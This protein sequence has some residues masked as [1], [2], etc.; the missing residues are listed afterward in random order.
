MTRT[1]S[2][3]AT[4]DLRRA[5]DQLDFEMVDV[6]DNLSMP[7]STPAFFEFGESPCLTDADEIEE[8]FNASEFAFIDV[9]AQNG[10]SWYEFS[11]TARVFDDESNEF[12]NVS[13]S[14]A[15]VSIFRKHRPL[16]FETFERIVRLVEDVLETSLEFD[17]DDEVTA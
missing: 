16:S 14:T 2:T 5:Y 8:K 10:A 13:V 4:D 1:S 17:A 3:S 11:V 9:F 7:T 6:H 12:C 15:G